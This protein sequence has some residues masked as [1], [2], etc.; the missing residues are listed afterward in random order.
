MERLSYIDE[1]ARSV[2]ANRERAWKALLTTMCKDP[3]DPST[4]PAGFVLDSAEAPAR[5]A[6]QGRHWFA[7]YALIFE[8]DEDGPSRT[9]VRARSWGDFPGPH[10][11]IY[12]ALVIGSGGHVLMVRMLLRRIAA[13]A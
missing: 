10:G 5:L 1:H 13:A 11:K 4:V 12:R 6:L 9:T 3:A 2:D 8:L 7:K